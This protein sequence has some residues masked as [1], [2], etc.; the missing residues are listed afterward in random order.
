ME[1]IDELL[2]QSFSV[3][4]GGKKA[5][6]LTSDLIERSARCSSLEEWRGSVGR[7]SMLLLAVSVVV[8][9]I[10]FICNCN[11]YSDNTIVCLCVIDIKIGIRY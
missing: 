5:E 8:V 10:L 9:E 1:D 11:I 3:A 4:C 7:L 2:N 6:P